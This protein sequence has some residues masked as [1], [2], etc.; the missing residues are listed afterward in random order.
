[1]ADLAMQDL[2]AGCIGDI[3]LEILAEALAIPE[4]QSF[5]AFL[6]VAVS[7]KRKP[8]AQ[9][10]RHVPDKRWKEIAASGRSRSNHNRAEGFFSKVSVGNVAYQTD[11]PDNVAF[12]I[13]MRSK[14]ARFPNIAA[15]RRVL[16]NHRIRNLNDLASNRSLQRGFDSTG[17]EARKDFSSNFPQDLTLR[18]P[19]EALHERVEKEITQIAVVEDDAFGGAID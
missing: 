19:R 3:E 16:G 4:S 17:H 8:H 18:L 12:G 13:T 2:L 9:S 1:M 7:D 15:V 11:H 14:R 6:I 10:I 5:R